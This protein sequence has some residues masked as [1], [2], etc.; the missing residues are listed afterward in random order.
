MTHGCGFA[1]LE[2]LEKHSVDAI[3]SDPPYG[4]D[5]LGLSWDKSFDWY[6]F[7]KECWRVVKPTGCVV[8]FGPWSDLTLRN[9][10]DLLFKLRQQIV[11]DRVKGRGASKQLVSTREDIYWYSRTDYYT[12]NPEMSNTKKNGR[13]GFSVKNGKEYRALTNVWT[14]IS[15][16]MFSMK[17]YCNHPCSKPIELM[18][19]IVRLFSNVGDLIVDPFAGSGSTAIAAEL[20]SRNY[21]TAEINQSWF[22]LSQKRM[23]ELT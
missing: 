5:Y 21:I 11:W 9:A 1:L 18:R 7:A 15:P 22:Q 2:S 4:I 17:E 10:F 14:D 23:T 20:E 6:R 8:I 12:F 13:S 19:R 3:I 16:E